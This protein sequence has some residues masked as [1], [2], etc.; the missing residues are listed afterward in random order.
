MDVRGEPRPTRNGV[1]LTVTELA[2]SRPVVVVLQAEPVGDEDGGTARNDDL[3]DKLGLGAAL[4]DDGVPAV[5]VLPPLPVPCARE[6]ARTVTEFAAAP[7]L[8]GEA[9]Q[10][11]LLRPVRGVIA[12]H[13][14]QVVLDDII[15][16]LNARYS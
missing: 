12:G 6:V 13:V 14:E 3:E 2:Q 4:I 11:D 7:G 16:F 1:L 8:S 10:V 9:V 15:L 5:L